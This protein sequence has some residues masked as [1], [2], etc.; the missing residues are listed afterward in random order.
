LRTSLGLE[1]SGKARTQVDRFKAEG[2]ILVTEPIKIAGTVIDGTQMGTS[3]AR[4]G[5]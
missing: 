3:S 1:E 2:W 4:K 5:S